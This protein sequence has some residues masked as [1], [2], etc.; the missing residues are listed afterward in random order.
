MPISENTTEFHKMLSVTAKMVQRMGQLP[1]ERRLR[2]LRLFEFQGRL[3][4]VG[5]GV[6]AKVCK[7][8]GAEARMKT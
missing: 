1:C 6:M 4:E 3:A 2:R 5:C 8:M 7:V